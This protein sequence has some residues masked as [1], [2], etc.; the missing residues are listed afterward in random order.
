MMLYLQML[1][2]W[3][4][5]TI[6]LLTCFD[7]TSVVPLYFVCCSSES[8]FLIV[9]VSLSLVDLLTFLFQFTKFRSQLVALVEE[10]PQLRKE[11]NIRHMES[12]VLVIIA[13]ASV[14]ILLCHLTHLRFNKCQLFQ[15]WNRKCSIE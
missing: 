2:Q 4:F 7:W 5:W 11:D 6:G 3:S 14:V 9:A 15:T 10:L 1:V 8:F 12:T 13:K